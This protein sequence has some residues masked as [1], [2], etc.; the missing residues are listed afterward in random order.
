MDSGVSQTGHPVYLVSSISPLYF[1]SLCWASSDW[2]LSLFDVQYIISLL[3]DL[4]QISQTDYL[5]FSVSSVWF[6]VSVESFRLITQFIWCLVYCQ[7]TLRS[8]RSLRLITQFIFW[9]SAH[10]QFDQTDTRKINWKSHYIRSCFQDQLSV[11]NHFVIYVVKN[12]LTSTITITI[13]ITF[14][15]NLQCDDYYYVFVI[16]LTSTSKDSNY[17]EH[18]RLMYI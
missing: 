18:S 8:I 13:T 2:S 1:W 15:W 3:W 10:H 7:S 17:N 16:I 11:S 6:Q 12:L 4:C 14:L 5:L 9:C